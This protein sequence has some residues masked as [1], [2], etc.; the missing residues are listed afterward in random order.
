MMSNQQA[1]EG[2]EKLEQLKII[3]TVIAEYAKAAFAN[4]MNTANPD[5]IL[6]KIQLELDR[7]YGNTSNVPGQQQ[8]ELA[9]GEPPVPSGGEPSISGEPVQG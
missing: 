3:G 9:A 6:Q 1:Q 2:K 5:V 7:M 8:P 4:P